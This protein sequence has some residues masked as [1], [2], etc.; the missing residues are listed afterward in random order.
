MYY[1]DFNRV[2]N[3][4]LYSY[5]QM[6][7]DPNW[8]GAWWLG[9]LILGSILFFASS[10][11]FHFPRSPQSSTIQYC[12]D[13]SNVNQWTIQE[14][15]DIVREII[16]P[17]KPNNRSLIPLMLILNHAVNSIVATS[18]TTYGMKFLERQY[19]L[20][21]HAAGAYFGTTCGI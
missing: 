9:Y 3:N 5:S 11:I 19:G 14:F 16:N 15:L 12:P 6:G 8:V 1:V 20:T 4:S 17:K 18:V 7:K 10:S 13:S 2:E 21:A